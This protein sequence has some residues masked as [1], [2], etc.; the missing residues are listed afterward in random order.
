MWN[1]EGAQW[2]LIIEDDVLYTTSKIAS[3]PRSTF[4]FLPSLEPV[5]H[6]FNNEP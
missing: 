1:N 4:V 2:C 5:H 6:G 3:A